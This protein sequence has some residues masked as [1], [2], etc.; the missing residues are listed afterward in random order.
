MKKPPGLIQRLWAE[1]SAAPEFANF[2]AVS[3]AGCSPSAGGSATAG[4]S[5]RATTTRQ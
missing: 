5:V 3:Y 4:F 2:I 1:I